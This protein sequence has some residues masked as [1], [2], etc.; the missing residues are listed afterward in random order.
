VTHR[1]EG[2]AIDRR[3]FC[4]LSAAAAVALS[5]LGVPAIAGDVVAIPASLRIYKVIFD[6]RFLAA[7]EFG[8]AAGRNGMRTAA[9]RGDIT[10]LWIDDLKAYWEA[11]GA[12]VAGMTTPR[13]LLCLEQLSHDTWRRVLRRVEYPTAPA[14]SE[15]QLVSWIIGS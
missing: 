2:A 7:R 9:I 8:S 15:A 11:D 13:T 1:G 10:A 5:S 6:E 14:R 3:D 12:A 4:G